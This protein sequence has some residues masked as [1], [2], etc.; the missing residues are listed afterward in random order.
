MTKNE[1]S[2]RT[3]VVA[4]RYVRNLGLTALIY[5]FTLA[6]FSL[7]FAVTPGYAAP[8]LLAEFWHRNVM[9]L[10]G[11]S[12]PP[13]TI[14]FDF[15]SGTSLMGE[16]LSWETRYGTNDVGMTFVA[17]QNV[18]DDANMSIVLPDAT[19]HLSSGGI[20]FSDPLRITS[21][22][23]GDSCVQVLVPDITRY[24]VT[25]VERIIEQ[26]EFIDQPLAGTYIFKTGQRIRYV[27]ELIPEPSTTVLLFFGLS[28]GIVIRSRC[29]RNYG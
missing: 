3:L 2:Q 29:M 26:L 22:S 9:A 8:I 25:S 18:V 19:F 5:S 13:A 1:I 27:G 23:C 6:L 20:R 21:P 24:T 14:L 15:E 12:P 11:P 28:A 4:R 17:P 7:G 10:S 16:F